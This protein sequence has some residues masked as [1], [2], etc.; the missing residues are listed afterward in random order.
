MDCMLLR[1]CFLLL[2]WNAAIPFA[3]AF[4]ARSI[5]SLWRSPRPSCSARLTRRFENYQRTE[6]RLGTIEEEATLG[7]AD[8]IE[9][10]YLITDSLGLQQRPSM[11]SFLLGDAKNVLG[12]LLTTVGLLLS[13]RNVFGRFD[14]SYLEFENMSY[15]LGITVVVLD[16]QLILQMMRRD[17][18]DD[19][20]GDEVGLQE[21]IS[22]NGRCGVIDDATVHVY[23]ATYTA[24]ATWWSLRTSMSCPSLIGDF[25]HIL[26]PLSL[27]IF[28][29]SI[30]AP[31][32][33][34]IHHY[35]DYQSKLVDRILKT[36]VGLARGGVTVDQL[37]RL[38][39]LEVYRATSLFVIGVIA[40]TYAPGTL[41]MTLRGQ[42]W[43]SRVMELH[44]GQSWIE[45][46]TALF[47]VYATQAS[48]VAHRAG[49][50]GVAT[51][52]QIVPAF[53]LLCLALT[54][55]P[56]ISSVYWLGDQ[57]SLVEFYGE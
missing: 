3:S 24:A 39:D 33:T 5:S 34:L 23:G 21:T 8:F 35:T 6:L 29:F 9:P 41:T 27:S 37:P 31:L 45:S 32:L 18:R 20:N 17:A 14:E 25:D 54:I 50:K 7:E 55:F 15:L 46:T 16:I 43:W 2:S 42:D 49:K 52:A 26:G 1:L 51:Y 40:C 48:M 38:S 13:T 10:D 44:P 30:T 56:T 19:S 36:I 4:V 22:P 12:V 11:Q 57:I 28:L 47:G 53:T